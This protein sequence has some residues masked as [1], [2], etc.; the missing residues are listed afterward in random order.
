[1]EATLLMVGTNGVEQAN[2]NLSS[3]RPGWVF[4]FARSYAQAKDLVQ[5][6]VPDAAVVESNLPQGS[7]L[8][9]ELATRNP[10]IQL[11][12]TASSVSDKYRSGVH[13][14]GLGYTLLEKPY[15]LGGLV[16]KIEQKAAPASTGCELCLRPRN[17]ALALY[18]PLTL[19][20]PQAGAG[21]A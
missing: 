14:D 5:H 13:H 10:N 15:S 21:Q 8:I 3:I 16:K 20:L 9:D 12:V 17:Q 4:L 1:M 7:R 2:R 19:T 18:R 6:T 11:F